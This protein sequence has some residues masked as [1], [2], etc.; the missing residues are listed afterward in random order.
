MGNVPMAVATSPAASHAGVGR[1]SFHGW[2]A[3]LT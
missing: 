1:S 3:S 2:G